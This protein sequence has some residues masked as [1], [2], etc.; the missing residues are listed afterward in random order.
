[1][2]TEIYGRTS[3]LSSYKH[4]DRQLKWTVNSTVN[5]LKVTD[6]VSSSSIHRGH[7]DETVSHIIT[8]KAVKTGKFKLKA[9]DVE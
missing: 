6:I 4:K 7:S 1:M 5:D 3:P 2:E 8:F 9:G